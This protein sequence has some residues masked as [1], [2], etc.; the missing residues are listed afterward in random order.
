MASE[1]KRENGLPFALQLVSNERMNFS[2][3]SF[4]LISLN[5]LSN[6]EVKSLVSCDFRSLD[7]V[8]VLVSLLE[9]KSTVLQVVKKAASGL[10]ISLDESLPAVG[11]KR[12]VRDRLGSSGDGHLLNGSV[13]NGSSKRCVIPPLF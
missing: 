10:D 9:F 7:I 8:R 6:D 5:F 12:S 4:K 11:A 2:D 1:K 13:F 3:F